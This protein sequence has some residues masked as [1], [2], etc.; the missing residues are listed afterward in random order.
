[1]FTVWPKFGLEFQAYWR[2]GRQLFEKIELCDPNH[3]VFCFYD[4]L[5]D[6]FDVDVSARQIQR[7]NASNWPQITDNYLVMKSLES[8]P[9]NLVW[10]AQW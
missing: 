10:L 7:H 5:C 9:I 3:T 1:M 2:L 6:V 8:C 4:D